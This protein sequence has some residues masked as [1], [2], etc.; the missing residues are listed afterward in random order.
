MKKWVNPKRKLTNAFHAEGYYPFR[1]AGILNRVRLLSM[2]PFL[3]L[4]LHF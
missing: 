4:Q 3:A 1:R 2:P